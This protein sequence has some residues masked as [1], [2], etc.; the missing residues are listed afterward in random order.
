MIFPIFLIA[1]TSL[2]VKS[3]TISSRKIAQMLALDFDGVIC[4]SALES[5]QT[6]LVAADDFWGKLNVN[7]DQRSIVVN[8]VMKLRPIIETGYENMIVAKL[9]A[10]M[11]QQNDI[12]YDFIK[13]SWTPDFRDALISKYSTSKVGINDHN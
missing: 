9:L 2:R 5:S 11:V 7:S 8:G 13:N 10:D 12:D 3:A 1:I 4:A 6:A